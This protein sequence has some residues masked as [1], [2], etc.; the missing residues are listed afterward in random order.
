MPNVQEGAELLLNPLNANSF[1]LPLLHIVAH[2][3]S[4][5]SPGLFILLMLIPSGQCAH[6]GRP[7]SP[8]KAAGALASHD[9]HRLIRQLVL[10]VK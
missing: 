7:F 9:N 8:D 2:S 1:F 4:V 3:V 10:S 5:K 6:D